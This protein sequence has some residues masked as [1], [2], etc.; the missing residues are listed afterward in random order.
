MIPVLF[1]AGP[2][3]AGKTEYAIRLARDLDGE[4]VSADSM[5]IYKYLDIGSAKPSPEELSMAKHY[6][7]DEIDPK[8]PFSAADYQKKALEYINLIH[9]KGKLP[10][11]SGGTGLYL[12]SLIYD[13]DF[14]APA[15]D[16]GIRQR[17]QSMED[18]APGSL[19]ERLRELDPHAADEIHPN[20]TKRLIRALERLEQGEGRLADFASAT[21][22]SPFIRPVLMAVNRDRAELYS[23]IDRRVDKI[24]DAGLESEVRGLMA[25]GFTSEDTAMKGIGYKEVMDALA[26]GLSADSAREQIKAASRRYAKRQLTWL[27]RYK[28]MKW[29]MLEGSDFNESV[30]AGMTEYGRKETH[31]P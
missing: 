1:L 19:W 31:N 30:Y 27:R 5:Q 14:S 24:F 26:A 9:Q 8:S 29:F 22:P 18:N 21:K 10:I 20:N 15:A 11:V 13:M 3:A 7:V 16:P 28:D 4:I 17:L 23:R 12:N 6:L 2:T 25:M